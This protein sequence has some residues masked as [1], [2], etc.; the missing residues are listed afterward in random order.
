VKEQRHDVKEDESFCWARTCISRCASINS[1]RGRRAETVLDRLVSR[2]E[3]Y[4]RGGVELGRLEHLQ[5]RP[6]NGPGLSVWGR[7]S[8]VPR[9][10]TSLPSRVPQTKFRKF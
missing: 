4:V 5:S 3:G 9:L 1:P 6:P 10:G 2:T 8:F 7:V